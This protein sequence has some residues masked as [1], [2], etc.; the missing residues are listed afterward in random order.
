MPLYGEGANVRDWLHVDDHCRGIHLVLERRA[1]GRGLQHRR[2]HRAD[3]QGAHRPLLDACGAD[4]DSVVHVEDRKGHD[5]RY[6]RRH[7]Q[8]PQRARLPSRAVDFEQGLA[9][10]VAAGTPTT[11]PG[12]SRSRSAPA[13][14]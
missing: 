3:Q 1:A 14:R 7:Q 10:T 11:A 5:L 6:S 2:R 13:H 9:D 4:W 12:G 8:D